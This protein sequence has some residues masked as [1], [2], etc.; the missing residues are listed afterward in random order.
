MLQ[1]SSWSCIRGV[2]VFKAAGQV[3]GDFQKKSIRSFRLLPC[4][5]ELKGDICFQKSPKGQMPVCRSSHFSAE[6]MNMFSS[7]TAWFTLV[8]HSHSDFEAVDSIEIIATV[9]C[10]TNPAVSVPVCSTILFSLY[11]LEYFFKFCF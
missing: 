1:N 11:C 8:T 9:S 5:C 2:E 7:I 10:Q 3:S 6:C 4:A